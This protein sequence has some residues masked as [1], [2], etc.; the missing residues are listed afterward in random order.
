M[1][2]NAPEREFVPRARTGGRVRPGDFKAKPQPV[3][4]GMIRLHHALAELGV[5]SRRGA[6]QLIREGFVLVNAHPVER[7]PALVNPLTDRVHVNGKP[8]SLKPLIPRATLREARRTGNP[9]H[10]DPAYRTGDSEVDSGAGV[11]AAGEETGPA[12]KTTSK[13]SSPPKAKTK[14][15]LEHEADQE[16]GS[17]LRRHY[18]MLYKPERY[19]T[20]LGDVEGE[21]AGSQRKTVADLVQVP[22]A[23]RLFPVGRLEFHASGLVFMTSDGQL[24]NR[25]TH[26]RFGVER[27]YRV[28]LRGTVDSMAA[29]RL[30]E[31]LN[32]LCI[33]MAKDAGAPIA[34]GSILA[35]AEVS[36]RTTVDPEAVGEVSERGGTRQGGTKTAVDITLKAGAASLKLPAMLTYLGAKVARIMQIALGPLT[37]RELAAG[38]WRPLTAGEVRMLKKAAEGKSDPAD[39]KAKR[40]ARAGASTK[41]DTPRSATPGALSAES[42]DDDFDDDDSDFEDIASDSAGEPE[43]RP[44]PAPQKPL[45]TRN[46][47]K[48]SKPVP[49][50]EEQGP[51]QRMTASQRPRTAPA[52]APSPLI[53][54]FGA[55]AR[56]P[57]PAAARPLPAPDFDA[58]L[59]S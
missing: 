42:T 33:R 38:Q 55:A 11:P 57:G 24:A 59:E 2:E 32:R 58:E 3:P 21:R 51:F 26:A 8:I 22:G 29:I 4:P 45:P 31:Q 34:P 50:A 27:T 54:R 5:A 28:W 44:I 46:P 30:G 7:L 14:R 1:L 41:T 20:A 19:L 52:V 49:L 15:D 40:P 16:P 25:L 9:L 17:A 23:L 18:I 37:L 56:T 12:V 47:P 39:A 10:G 6:E 36:S 35:R 43:A 53:K 13:K 48:R